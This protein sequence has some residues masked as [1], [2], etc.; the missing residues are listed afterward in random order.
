M[1]GTGATSTA[2]PS[3]L[4]SVTGLRVAFHHPPSYKLQNYTQA[5]AELEMEWRMLHR[6][7]MYNKIHHPVTAQTEGP[8]SCETTHNPINSNKLTTTGGRPGLSFRIIRCYKSIVKLNY[9]ESSM[10]DA[11]VFRTCNPTRCQ[12]MPRAGGSRCL[13]QAQL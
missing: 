5:L 1:Y 9:N 10:N 4:F 8:M 7:H 3:F 11:F 12:T 2:V 6:C 13:A